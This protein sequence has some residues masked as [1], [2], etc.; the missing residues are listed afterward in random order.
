VVAVNELGK[1]GA[2]K[3]IGNLRAF[4]KGGKNT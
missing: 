4:I 2:V 3:N 1:E